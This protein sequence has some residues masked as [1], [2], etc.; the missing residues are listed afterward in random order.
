MTQDEGYEERDS[1][2]SCLKWVSVWVLLYQAQLALVAE[3]IS[4]AAIIHWLCEL[5]R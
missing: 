3:K 2:C 1:R 4:C 5:K